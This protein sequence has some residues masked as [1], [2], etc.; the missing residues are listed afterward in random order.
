MPERLKRGTV[1]VC[2]EEGRLLFWRYHKDREIWVT[3]EKFESMREKDKETQ[4]RHY[5]KYA[6]RKAKQSAKWREDNEERY[7]ETRARWRANNREHILAKNAEYRA[8]KVGA[9]CEDHCIE[10]EKALIA[11]CR[12]L[13]AIHGECGLLFH[14]DHIVPLSQGG[15]HHHDNLQVVPAPWNLSKSANS[16][17]VWSEQHDPDLYPLVQQ[18]VAGLLCEIA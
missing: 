10:T 18:V 6:E 11:A 9:T 8:M 4:R 12:E 16:C 14:V 13:E 1:K 17:E 3:P 15:K 2:P 7:K 5:H